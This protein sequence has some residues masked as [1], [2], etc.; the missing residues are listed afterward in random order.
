MT[1]NH[2]RPRLW[3]AL[4]A[5]LTMTAAGC[6]SE[7]TEG[8]RPCPCSEGW[9]C[10]A[11][12]CVPEGQ[13][14]AETNQPPDNQPPDNLPPG[15]PPPDTTA[16][17]A[18]RFTEPSTGLLT[19]QRTMTIKGT[20]EANAT[21]SLYLN[22]SCGGGAAKTTSADTEGRF[23][24]TITVGSNSRTSLSANARDAA[25]NTSLCTSPA[26]T[27][28]H[29]DLSPMVSGWSLEGSTI[30]RATS[31]TLR[32]TTEAAARVS[33]FL[34][35]RCEGTPVAEQAASA[36]GG[37]IFVAETLANQTAHWTVR[38]TDAAGNEGACFGWVASYT[39]DDVAPAAPAVTSTLPASGTSRSLRLDGTAEP[40]TTVMVWMNATCSSDPSNNVLVPSGG[41]W[42]F[43]VWVASNTTTQA[44]VRAKDPG[45]NLSECVPLGGY[46][47]DELP[48]AIPSQLA[49]S[50][51][52]P[53][54]VTRT[55]EL[56]G[57]TE[58]DARVF[59]KGSECGTGNGQTLGETQAGED[60]TFRI[61]LTLP[62]DACTLLVHARDALGN[63]SGSASLRYVYDIIPPP[64]PERL[65][66]AAPSPS[67]VE[68][69][70][71]VFG[72][73]PLD[74][75]VQVFSQEE[76]Q[77]P[78]RAEVTSVRG[79]TAADPTWF[80]APLEAAAE[81]TTRYSARTVDGVG[82]ASGCVAV[83]G[84]FG[85][86]SD[87]PGWR[88]REE[89]SF[90]PRH[91]THDEQGFTFALDDQSTSDS[92]YAP[93][94]VKVA[95]RASAGD[96][97]SWGT[98]RVLTSVASYG[99]EPRLAVN[100]RGDAAVVWAEDYGVDP[101]RL[102]RFDSRTGAWSEPLAFTVLGSPTG[103]VAVALDAG[104]NVTA[105]WLSQHSDGFRVWCARVPAAGPVE[106]PEPLAMV[107]STTRLEGALTAGGHVLLV[108]SWELGD[109]R[110]VYRA[111]THVPGAGWGD[112]SDPTQGETGAL[113]MGATR[114]GIGWLAY[115]GVFGTS[116]R[117]FD[118]A[119]GGLQAAELVAPR[120]FEQLSVLLEP[121]GDTVIGA[122][123]LGSTTVWV[124]HRAPGSTWAS[125]T[126]IVPAVFGSYSVKLTTAAPGEAW[127]FWDDEYGPPAQGFQTNYSRAGIWAQRFR[128]GTGWGEV[129]LLEVDP[130]SYVHLEAADGQPNGLVTL[131]W[132]HVDANGEYPSALRI[133]R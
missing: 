87:A 14:C 63:T 113:R 111:R 36:A 112:T 20:A 39:H 68:T 88:A 95:R 59:I 35:E 44:S 72:T 107:A 98:P 117:R 122:A 41:S 48:P 80:E 28:D 119:A 132:R 126:V 104:G 23:E 60:G 121:E 99:G 65:R 93:K 115:S 78:V 133:F 9:T 124:G 11:N 16:P 58:P 106:T 19:R 62:A 3:L 17:A 73:A 2:L 18:P 108:W 84:A 79:P 55:P 30:G 81:V 94:R 45:N 128:A 85:H 101:V 64:P 13:S 100:A 82:N 24:L 22:A 123:G 89:L 46:I 86:A 6:T 90:G 15:N 40:G 5:A 96:G 31:V 26:L 114:H 12:K 83:T 70:V 71:S 43:S 27:V 10:C 42:S 74:A 34:G 25:G 75:R 67:A 51:A 50:P 57:L 129:R 7:L 61:T 92:S 1:R 32:G 77:G 4:C 118:P 53:N 127:L 103:Q 33:L 38:A 29:D 8:N 21:V 69:R 130:S 54:N 110:R 102:V 52:S 47:H 56:T 66:L 76:C 125:S 131:T 120:A 116:L 49:T 105:C 91:L 109:D 97:T 37:F